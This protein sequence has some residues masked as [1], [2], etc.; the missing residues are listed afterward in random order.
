VVLGIVVVLVAAAPH[1]LADGVARRGLAFAMPRGIVLFIGALCFILFLTE[2][3]MLDWSAV[4]LTTARAVPASWAGL[5]YAAFAAMM[6]LGRLTGDGIVKRLGIQPVILCGGLC[7]AFGLVLVALV[8]AWEAAIIGYALVGAGCAN[9][10]PV[11][12]TAVGRQTVMAE[13]A[14]VPAISVLGY[15]GILVGPAAIGFVAHGTSLAVALLL[16]ATLLVGVAASSAAIG[17]RH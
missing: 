7:A 5:G 11:L 2:G 4:F 17:L 1:L 6:T 13:H 12:Y 15:A 14:A 9:I 3:A 16:L 8:P 10:V